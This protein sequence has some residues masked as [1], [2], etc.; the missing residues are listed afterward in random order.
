[1]SRLLLELLSSNWVINNGHPAI[2]IHGQLTIIDEGLYLDPHLLGLFKAQL[3]LGVRSFQL[4]DLGQPPRQLCLGV[5]LEALRLLDL[6][7]G[8]SSLGCDFHQ[9]R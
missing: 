8:S 9:V 2:F 4:L 5:R 7:L 6:L 3:K 1:M